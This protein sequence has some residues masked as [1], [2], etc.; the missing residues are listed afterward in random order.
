MMQFFNF[1]MSALNDPMA[2]G[3][4]MALEGVSPDMLNSAM[5]PQGQQALGMLMQPQADQMQQPQDAVYRPGQDTANVQQVGGN[6]IRQRFEQALVSGN[7]ERGVVG[8][9][10]PNAIAAVMSTGQH[11]SAFNPSNVYGT[12]N[13][14]SEKGQAGTSG[15]VLSWRA[16]RLQNLFNYAGT[17]K[18]P[19]V[20]TQ[21]SFF[22]EENPQLI[23]QLEA[24]ETPEQAQQL[25]NN[26]WRFAGYD[27]PGGEAAERIASA[28][29]MTG[30]IG[31]DF[32]ASAPSSDVNDDG[33]FTTADMTSG[34]TT[35][36]M[37]TD[38]PEKTRAQQLAAKI[39]QI[40]KGL[41]VPERQPVEAPRI[42]GGL[43]PDVG[44]NFQPA[45]MGQL[46]ALLGGQGP[47]QGLPPLSQL[48]RGG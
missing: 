43:A 46:F 8:L 12:W 19:E 5:A 34:T 21:A 15:G 47:K 29:S 18:P 30:G 10:N 22:L 17:D 41:K 33:K 44:G 27:K 31:S 13:D 20:E 25:M 2:A 24:A 38:A 28:R 23:R 7:S 11:E 16:E 26:A 14:P 37:A 4:Q 1:V 48:I 39:A 32:A 36:G 42:T 40:G 9:K 6:D 45:D 3:T 35:T